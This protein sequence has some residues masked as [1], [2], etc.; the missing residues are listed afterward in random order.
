MP[1]PVE[2][3]QVG[4]VEERVGIGSEFIGAG[5]MNSRLAVRSRTGA[6]DSMC[7][8][9]LGLPARHCKKVIGR[10]VPG[11]AALRSVSVPAVAV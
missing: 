2:E 6:N 10:F 11:A 5:W 8:Q 3:H 7:S 1:I 9:K 4:L